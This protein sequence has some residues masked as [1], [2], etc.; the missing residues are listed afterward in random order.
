VGPAG[1]HLASLDADQRTTL[2]QD[3]RRRVRS[4]PFT[5]TALAWAARGM[6]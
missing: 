2:R 5:V 1:A 4:E 3:C 6:A